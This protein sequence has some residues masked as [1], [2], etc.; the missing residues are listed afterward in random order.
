MG[1]ELT[2]SKDNRMIAG[3]CGG[4]GEY[5]GVD[6]VVIRLIW[7]VITIFSFGI[8]GVLAYVIAWVIMPEEKQA[9][10]GGI[11]YDSEQAEQ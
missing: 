2:R 7:A 1:K 6:P 10:S 11:Q 5:I 3:V 4:I 9:T 8:I